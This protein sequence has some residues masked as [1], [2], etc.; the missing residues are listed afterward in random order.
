M[1]AI[2]INERDRTDYFAPSTSSFKSFCKACRARYGLDNLIREET[3]LDIDFDFYHN[4]LDFERTFQVK[5]NRS[6]YI[7]R[8]VVLAIGGGASNIPRPFT[9]PLSEGASHAMN[10]KG[11]SLLS[12]ELMRKINSGEQTNILVVGGGLTSAQIADAVLRRGVSRVWLLMRG[13]WKG[14]IR[15]LSHVPRSV[16]DVGH[17]Q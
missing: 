12:T 14:E 1:P 2:E 7:A 9:T 11:E 5:T 16:V 8:F 4:V 3:V 13:P 6:V 15:S 10:L 17:K